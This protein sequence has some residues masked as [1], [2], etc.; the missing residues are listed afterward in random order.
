MSNTATV[1]TIRVVLK[2]GTEQFVVDLDTAKKKVKEVHDHAV[3]GSV[4]A[5]GALRALEGQWANNT[6]AIETYLGSLKG[7]GPAL[8]AVFPVVGFL[9]VSAALVEMGKKAY[10]AYESLERL[11]EAPK[12]IR[13]GFADLNRPIEIT[14]AGLAKQAD[15]LEN[16]IAK[17]QGKPQNGLKV[18][19]DEALESSFKLS[20]SIQQN[21]KDLGNFLETQSFGTLK[22]F[23]TGQAPNEEIKKH[24]DHVI[25]QIDA[26]TT[27]YD[28][29]LS[30]I[31]PNSKGAKARIDALND[32]KSK[33]L[34]RLFNDALAYTA[35]QTEE[36]RKSQAYAN[37][38]VDKPI[39]VDAYG[40]VISTTKA[41]RGGLDQTAALEYLSGISTRFRAAIA[42]LS[43]SRRVTSDQNQ[44][45]ILKANADDGAAGG[46]AE[47]RK[48]TN[49]EVAIKLRDILNKQAAEFQKRLENIAQLAADQN[50]KD[51]QARQAYEANLI[52]LNRQVDA[53]KE[54]AEAETKGADAV[55]AA[56]KKLALAAIND[57]IQRRLTGQLLDQQH[58]GGINN[59][60]AQIDRQ[61]EATK[62]LAAVANAGRDAQR[63][64]EI[65]NI[66][67]SGQAKEIIEAQVK[68]IQERHKLENKQ[69][70][71]TGNAND[72]VKRY[73][74]EMRDNVQ[75]TAAQVHNVLG[76]AFMGLND[77]LAA[78]LSG[79]QASWSSFFAGLA[80]R[81]A[82]VGLANLEGKLLGGLFGGTSGKS[83]GL[84][85]AIF[86][87]IGHRASGGPVRAGNPYVVGEIGQELFVPDQP[88][89]II[90]NNKLGGFKGGS[91]AYYSIDARGANAADVE[92]RVNRSLIAV[93]GHAVRSA[94]AVQ[95]EQRLRS[96]RSKFQ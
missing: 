2:A 23:I 17:L 54:L 37:E 87:G 77:T 27:A 95:T 55:Y 62:K 90:P 4:A 88:G 5:S 19:L 45:N 67:N 10:E 13:Q 32:A 36:R 72:G 30:E 20:Q 14:N 1:G 46:S 11:A 96:P 66:R 68:A 52:L 21:F 92:A 93:H 12:H 49:L 79:Q 56:Q 44:L 70:L 81:I 8:Q 6:T 42:N 60:V 80:A 73:F 38:I 22:G 53:A 39:G 18:A 33:G 58:A 74:T 78:M 47:Q 86:G 65:E 40:R 63:R 34:L 75:S 57:P 59:A 69:E 48:N 82:Q 3:S 94:V 29:Q 51:Q 43:L 41:P 31:D 24:F 15:L 76:G 26:A 16:E 89:T 64:A 84:L 71:I 25:A 7:V 61:T 85:S 28:V 50:D 83:G 35:S 9:G 91:V